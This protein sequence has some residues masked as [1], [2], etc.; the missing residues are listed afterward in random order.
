MHTSTHRLEG[1]GLVPSHGLVVARG[2]GL[3]LVDTAWGV[4]ETRALMAAVRARFG[5]L[6]AAAVVTHAHDDRV[7]GLPVLRA[8]GVPVFATAATAARVPDGSFAGALATPV[9]ARALGGI[10]VEVFAPGPAHTPDNVVVWLPAQGTLFGGCM[11][12]PAGA[13]GPRDLADADLASWPSSA[14]QVAARYG[15][16]RVVIPSHGEPGDASLPR[17][18][19]TSRTPRSARTPLRRATQLPV[20]DGATVTLCG[21]AARRAAMA[22]FGPANAHLRPWVRLEGDVAPGLFVFPFEAMT[23]PDDAPVCLTGR[24]FHE[25]P[26]YPGD[27]PHAARMSGAWL[28]DA[29]V[30]DPGGG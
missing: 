12:R 24:Y 6:P 19:S 1:Y 2:E 18:P 13:P 9:D 22:Q 30:T 26:L 4:D 14:L 5:R 17:T 25:F 7:G 15:A 20:R 11:I 23:A 16:A 21:R 28:M 29:R 8:L 3:L 10:D 27:P